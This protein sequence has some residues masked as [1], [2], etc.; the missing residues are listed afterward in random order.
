M[1]ID[2]LHLKGFKS[3]GTPQEL[4]FSP[5]LT[6]IVGPNGSGKSNLLDALRW[7]LGENGVQRLRITKQSDLLFSGSASVPPS[8]RAEVTLSIRDSE[9]KKYRSC[10]FK[11]SYSPE[12]GTLFTVD[13]LRI[14]MADLPEVKR[15]WHLEGDQFA[16]ISQGEVAEAIHQRPS[17]RRTHLEMLFG[18]DH[19]RRKR[20]ETSLKLSA[21]EEEGLRLEALLSELGNRRTEIAAA[22]HRATEAAALRDRLEEKRK[23][24]YHYHRFRL[25]EA[26][27]T[28]E[29]D[30]GTLRER[31]TRDAAWL[32]AWT[33]LHNRTDEEKETLGKTVR[34]LSNEAET[35]KMRHGEIRRMCFASATAI[36]EIRS[37]LDS[38]LDERESL[39]ASCRTLER[40]FQDTL[41]REKELSDK[42][43]SLTAMR[44]ELEGEA[45]VL[46]QRMETEK[47]ERRERADRLTS[48][49]AEKDALLGIISTKEAFLETCR[50]D[51]DESNGTI[52]E[53]SCGV[54]SGREE[55]ALLEKEEEERAE[56]YR[57]ILTRNRE[58][59]TVLQR[60]RKER[61]ELE[62][63][64]EDL[65]SKESSSLPEPVRFL[66]SAS[67]L[68]K[69]DTPMR[70]ALES[71]T[72]PPDIAAALEAYLAGRQ[73]WI[74]VDTIEDAARL[75]D[76]LKKER[77]GRATFLPLERARP[78]TPDRQFPLPEQDVVGWAL[79]LITPDP[80]WVRGARHILGD[81]LIIKEYSL[82]A[83]LVRKKAPFPM[84]TLDG[85]VFA[86]SGTISGG[87]IRSSGGALE[88]RVLIQQ[89]EERLEANG[90]ETREL[91]RSLA[92]TE[93]LEEKSAAAREQAAARTLEKRERLRE[94]ERT[95]SFE[96]E[97]LR[98]LEKAHEEA[99]A[100]RESSKKKLST[101]EEELR[102]L[103]DH[104]APVGDGEGS[105]GILS[106]LGELAQEIAITEERL[107]SVLSVKARMDGEMRRSG[108]R[109]RF[110]DTEHRDAL[111]REIAEREK[112]SRWGKEQ[113][114][115]ITA[116]REKRRALETH[117]SRRDELERSL[118]LVA[119]RRQR[120]SERFHA[121]KDRLD[122]ATQR[123]EAIARELR[124][125]I[126]L[127][128]EQFPY[129]S[130]AETIT[131]REGEEASAACRRL[132]RELRSL[133]EVEWGALSED[134][135]LEK[136][137]SFLSEQLDDARNAIAELRGILSDTDRQVGALF[138][139]ALTNINLRFDGLF[140]R[141]FGGGEARLRLVQTTR[142]EGGEPVSEE[143]G[144]PSSLWDSGVEIVARPPGKH[145]QNLAQLSGGEQTLTAIAHL[146]A[147]MEV[148]E[149]PLAVLDEV[150]A[151]L[152]EPN[153]LRFGDL[154][155][156]YAAPKG[157]EHGGKGM[158]IIVMTHRRATMERADT[159]Y[160]VA[161]D[162]PGLS[163]AL[164]FQL[165]EWEGDLE[166]ETL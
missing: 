25:E 94:M 81:L 6:A 42:N 131:E 137:I 133:G 130:A 13:G 36:R 107:S 113:L 10:L 5:G 62:R 158:Q 47:K 121:T 72:C 122:A 87:R 134:Q 52:A 15:L 129:T 117:Q 97:R 69:T 157:T 147:S 95:L 55:L 165:R 58:T 56:Q 108:E 61:H 79:D 33:E 53:A 26:I 98:R 86:P 54:A 3:F 109:L 78:R 32:K 40:E 139:E 89:T 116:H 160:G 29:G 60:A 138:T 68:G 145:L 156:E 88:R 66:A 146:F 101:L 1:F 100:E 83:L 48:L 164:G 77:T 65:Q 127:W 153:L 9:E 43:C 119:K 141:L 39:A 151:A 27:R 8:A 154:A 18:I 143:E 118:L 82:G 80:R 104:D 46:R 124:Q 135:S 21:A 126:E 31:G 63:I 99:L 136:R 38:L 96:K 115:L 35:L 70:I 123:K 166:E 159:L 2:R 64:V 102:S 49:T 152:D 148:A 92:D 20:D 144:S 41:S 128:D 45:A 16:F 106:R 93:R 91:E 19:Y 67:K 150:D 111:E 30:F 74:F 132:E 120:S 37:R 162:E 23:I 59:A 90:R 149:V 112:L 142:D 75:I 71:F 84:V 105:D 125:N 155:K 17:Q 114:E 76:M 73:H 34:I 103:S 11:R 163:K 24:Q 12:T 44:R 4:L 28:L 110:L 14:R 161:L 22:V 140:R 7:V 50:R 85:E 57:V 51:I